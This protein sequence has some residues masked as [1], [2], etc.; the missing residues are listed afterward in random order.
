LDL[1]VQPEVLVHRERKGRKAPLV[2]SDLKVF[3]V[4]K[5]QQAQSDHKVRLEVLVLR[6]FRVRLVQQD[7]KAIKDLLVV[8]DR[9]EQLDLKEMMG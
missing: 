9:L 4:L 7:R 5:V 1:K 3:K 8:L 6:A 2:Q